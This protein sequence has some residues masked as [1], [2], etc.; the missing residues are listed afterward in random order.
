[1]NS[2]LLGLLLMF[3]AMPVQGRLV[4]QVKAAGAAAD[5]LR[6]DSGPEKTAHQVAWKGLFFY[7][8]QKLSENRLPWQVAQL[9]VQRK[10]KQGALVL[11]GKRVERFGKT[12]RAIGASVWRH[13][14]DG[15]YGNLRLELAPQ[16]VVLPRARLHAQLYQGIGAWEIAGGYGWRSAQPWPIHSF[17][18]GVGWYVGSWYIYEQTTVIPQPD[19]WALAQQCRIRYYL[20]GADNYLGVRF[21]A[22]RV[23]TTTAAGPV[24]QAVPT[25]FIAGQMQQ[26]I[27]S[28]WGVSLLTSYSNDTF[29]NRQGI[30]AGLIARW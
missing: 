30:M 12:D 13:L 15:S 2:F 20:K 9:L 6:N 23:I 14:W 4:P 11:L 28:N 29:F 18:V 27:S 19:K 1:M 26:F 21:G 16:A 7:N 8:Y 25:Y 24:V 5:S 17:N 22:G 3:V 10:S